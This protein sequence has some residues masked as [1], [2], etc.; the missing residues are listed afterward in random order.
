MPSC[1][2]LKTHLFSARIPK[3]LFKEILET[4]TDDKKDQFE[5]ERSPRGVAKI[6][7][8]ETHNAMAAMD[9]VGYGVEANTLH[10]QDT[11]S[12]YDMVTL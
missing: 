10:T 3:K 7:I 1:A 8:S 4:A 9:F 12:R 2:A 11:F 5:K 6:H